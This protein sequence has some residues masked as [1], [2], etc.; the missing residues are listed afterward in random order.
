[1][2]AL[3]PAAVDLWEVPP[4]VLFNA[5]KHHAGHLRRR[6]A[7]AV[8]DGPA[9]IETLAANLVVVGTELMDLYTGTLRPA[10]I[11][12]RLLAQLRAEGRGEPEAFRAWVAEAGGYRLLTLADDQSGWL[13]RAGDP[14]GRFVHVHPGRRVPH[15]IRVRANVLKTAVIALAYAG[16][17]GGDPRRVAT[18]NAAR[19]RLGLPPVPN[20]AG[21]QGLGLILDLL[22]GT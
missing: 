12:D 13:L 4:Q 5:W 15:T 11:A 21:D 16:V 6:V 3:R 7:G 14:D 22:R 8:A 10:E 1:V 19:Q 9:G 2:T 20:V 18:V 17:H